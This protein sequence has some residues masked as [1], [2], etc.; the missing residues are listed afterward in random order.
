MASPHIAGRYVL[1]KEGTARV[2]RW[3]TTNASSCSIACANATCQAVISTRDL[4]RFARAIANAQ[5]PVDIPTAILE[6]LADV[7]TGRQIC[8]NW[9][10]GQVPG[11]STEDATI[12]S[13][14]KSHTHFVGVLQDIYD[15][16]KS[17]RKSQ[18]AE[19]ASIKP[20]AA[21]S[22][23]TEA[24]AK[25][26]LA[27]LFV[28]LELEQPSDNPLGHA[29]PQ[30]ATD[31][32]EDSA[33]ANAADSSLELDDHAEKEFA[34]WCFLKDLQEIRVYLRENW[35]DYA[36][37][38]VSFLAVSSL[39]DTAFGVMRRADAALV[40]AHPEFKQLQG[41]LDCLDVTLASRND[42]L[43][44]VTRQSLGQQDIGKE[45]ADLLCPLGACNVLQFYAM[46]ISLES[47][48]QQ[49][50]HDPKAPPPQA[51]LDKE[52]E[53]QT[54]DPDGHK[55]QPSTAKTA[56]AAIS[57]HPF[58]ATLLLL[59]GQIARLNVAEHIKSDEHLDEFLEGLVQM[60]HTGEFR[61]W[62]IVAC[63]TYMDIFDSIKHRSEVGLNELARVVKQSKVIS[64]KYLSFTNTSS[65]V[66]DDALT[67][68]IRAQLCNDLELVQ[69]VTQPRMRDNVSVQHDELLGREVEYARS[70]YRDMPVLAGVRLSW[71]KQIMLSVGIRIAN[72]RWSIL[73]IAHLYKALKHYKLIESDWKD[74][75]W[76][77]DLQSKNKAF[78]REMG[79][80]ADPFA[81][82]RHF[83]LAMGIPVGAT[84]TAPNSRKTNITLSDV[85]SRRKSV[86]MGSDFLYAMQER[87]EADRQLGCSRGEIIDVVLRAM[88]EK[89]AAGGVSGKR[90]KQVHR[91]NAD[92]TGLQ[93]LHTYKDLVVNDEPELNFDYIRFWM[94][95]TEVLV[96]IRK[97]C[98][99]KLAKE[100]CEAGFEALIVSGLL[101]DAATYQFA[102][103][104][105]GS[106]VIA[107]AATVLQKH[108][109]AQ[110]DRFT[111]AAF[112]QSSGHIPTNAQF[113]PSLSAHD[114]QSAPRYVSEGVPEAEDDGGAQ[115]GVADTAGGNGEAEAP[116]TGPDVREVFAARK[117][118]G[119]RFLRTR[120]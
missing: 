38:G 88:R 102:S 4:L 16:L 113:T 78:V 100:F 15:M 5:S 62:L 32:P 69:C 74:M 57:Y 66:G 29:P 107:K 8:A 101:L 109:D 84:A 68:N 9:Y 52:L 28:G 87:W 67:K 12:D 42:M 48:D 120:K 93:L 89:K 60:K 39:T 111:K 31:S 81:L 75:D 22:K 80:N 46:W 65:R 76:F 41:V 3:L 47:S 43:C 114:E 30:S 96:M 70:L 20:K 59:T 63:Q 110:G 98:Q 21:A 24:D 13:S 2:V 1:Y 54:S 35:E 115:G 61:M 83:E 11:V 56:L 91:E 7:I 119:R 64:D 82:L 53:P 77:I 19:K 118:R 25:E 90:P 112:E 10:A 26:S 23:E 37:G 117:K 105:L 99:S 36:K 14:N 116:E 94:S 49:P 51:E 79:S 104:P 6:L 108:I 92:V 55:P 34:L 72:K 103:R 33:A 86:R 18:K 50:A 17:A 40:Q 44:M 71:H 45:A 73:G 85:R 58:A 95:C 97:V 106:S 27:N